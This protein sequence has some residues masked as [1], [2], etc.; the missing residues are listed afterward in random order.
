MSQR[1]SC[2]DLFF[3]AALVARPLVVF[4]GE[5][6]TALAAAARR[7]VLPCIASFVVRDDFWD[8]RA[9]YLTWKRGED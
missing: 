6:I 2:E 7:R 3:F 9:L 4:K 5:S 8:F 1:V